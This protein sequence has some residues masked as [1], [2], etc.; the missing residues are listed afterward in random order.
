MRSAAFL[1]F[2]PLLSR[3]GRFSFS[4]GS[5]I[6]EPNKWDDKN[7]ETLM[8]AN[9]KWSDLQDPDHFK[10]NMRHHRPNILWIGCSDARIPANELIGEPVG[11]VFVHR[12]IANMVVNTDF[13]CMSVVQYA[14]NVLKVRHII[15]CGHYDCGGVKAALSNV[16][17]VSPLENWLRNIRDVHRLHFKEL[18]ELPDKQAIERR[19]VELNVIEQ[20]LNLFK[21]GVVQA[22]RVEFQERKLRGEN[23]PFLEP[24]IHPLVYEP[25][26][27]VAKRLDVDFKGVLAGLKAVYELY[28]AKPNTSPDKPV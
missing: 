28:Q 10:F 1:R 18:S 24:R 2:P 4:T 25:T 17:N 12:N 19:L 8:Q 11:S 16:N 15:V 6:P 14:I 22:K 7:L 3:L 20:C 23:V 13:N 26:T 27:G 9:R 5:S 21:T